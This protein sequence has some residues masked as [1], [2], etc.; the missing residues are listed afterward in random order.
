[1]KSQLQPT[2]AFRRGALNALPAADLYFAREVQSRAHDTYMRAIYIRVTN[3]RRCCRRISFCLRKLIFAISFCR[4]VTNFMCNLGVRVGQT[5]LFHDSFSNSGY[6]F[7]IYNIKNT[8][9][10]FDFRP[11]LKRKLLN[12]PKIG[13]QISG[14]H[15]GCT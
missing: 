11:R 10:K 9:S 7:Y 14:S 1:M 5:F 4:G 15:G 3:S 13:M 12:G 6:L 2:Y 8:L